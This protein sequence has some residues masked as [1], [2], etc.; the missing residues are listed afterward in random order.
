MKKVAQSHKYPQTVAAQGFELCDL[1]R[2]ELHKSHKQ[3]GGKTM[4][5]GDVR[6]ILQNSGYRI[7]PYRLKNMSE[8]AS[9]IVKLITCNPV[10][11]YTNEEA[12]F[13]L[14]TVSEIIEWGKEE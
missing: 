10:C 3:K 13:I 14:R 2:T 5:S 1:G 7:P 4:Q 11:G 6:T 9:K 8:T 12:R